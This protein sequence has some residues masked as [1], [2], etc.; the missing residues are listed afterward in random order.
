MKIYTEILY[1]AL[2]ACSVGAGLMILALVYAFLNSMEWLGQKLSLIFRS[3][4]RLAWKG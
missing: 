3:L 1:I 2:M 4:K